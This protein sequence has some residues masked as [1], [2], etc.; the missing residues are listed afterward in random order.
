MRRGESGMKRVRGE[1]EEHG[2]A[3]RVT[4]RVGDGEGCDV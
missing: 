1:G 2:G 4:Q 3:R